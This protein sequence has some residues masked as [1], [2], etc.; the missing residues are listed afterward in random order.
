LFCSIKFIGQCGAQAKVNLKILVVDESAD[1]RSV[2]ES[3]LKGRGFNVVCAA[4]GKDALEKLRPDNFDLILAGVSIPSM[5]SIR[6]LQEC[7]CDEKLKR[8][9]FILITDVYIDHDDEDLASKIGAQAFIRRPLE[10]DDLVNTIEKVASG[11]PIALKRGRKP[12]P[13]SLNKAMVA[14]EERLLSR[15]E[16]RIK[17]LET[18]I[19]QHK[20]DKKAMQLGE[21]RYHLL[22]RTIPQGVVFQDAS[23]SIISANPAALNILG[24]SEDQI[25]GRTSYDPRWRAIREDGSDYPGDQHPAMIALRTGQTVKGAIMG[26]FNP[27]KEEYR[28]IKIDAIPLVENGDDRPYQ[29]YTTFSD[30]T[31]SFL[32][33]RA[34]QESESRLYAIIENTTD[35]IFS[36]DRDSHVIAANTMAKKYFQKAL[37]TELKEGMNMISTLDSERKSFWQDIIT[38]ALKGE[39]IIFEWHYDMDHQPLDLEFS[40]NPIIS[41]AGYITGLS[42]FGRDITERKIL[43]RITA[44]QHGLA[45]ALANTEEMDAAL[46][47][48]LEAALQ[49]SQMDS[50][51]VYLL[52]ESSGAFKAS[53]Y[54]G[55]SAETMAKFGYFPADSDNT[56]LIMRGKPSYARNDQFIPPFDEQFKDE[57]LTFV[58]TVP[59]LYRQK[60]TACLVL[61]S[62]EQNSIPEINLRALET[63][64]SDIGIAIERIKAR[65]ALRESEEKYRTLLDEMDEAY[66]EIDEKGNYTFFNDALCRMFGY[67]RQELMGM[68]YKVYTRPEDIKKHVSIF[69]SVYLTG[70]PV[71]RISL[72]FVRKDGKHVYVEESILPVRDNEGKIVGL[73]GLVHDITDR[74]EHEEKL[75]SR[76]LLLDSAYD[77]IIAF[78]E[79]GEISYVNE[80][81]AR[82][83][84]YTVDQLLSMNIRQLVHPADIPMLEEKLATA[85]READLS[86]E[87]ACVTGDNTTIEVEA[88]VRS[89]EI[90][91]RRVNI[92]VLRDITERKKMEEQLKD[93]LQQV[94]MTLEGTIEAIATMSEIRDPY[95]A[96][97]QHRVTRL[98][99][100]IAREMGL[101]EEK[102]LALRVAGLLHDVGKVYV[103]SEILSKPGKLA[104]LERNLVRAHAEAG[105]NIVKTIKFPW[106]VCRIVLQHHERMNGSGYP[107][108]L[109]GDQIVAEARILAV[110]DVVEAMLSHRPYRPALGL[111]K[112]LEEITT[113][114]GILYDEQAVDACV[115]LFTEKGFTFDG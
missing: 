38:R 72:V 63:I 69:S 15:L 8:I 93:A 46:K 54:K 40:V 16:G 11:K 44:I 49:I 67:S 53:S 84:H 78:D 80:T 62:H 22:F 35:A 106:P 115:R 90:E 64:A 109:K 48:C 6:L 110:A 39:R 68:N 61:C 17:E 29:V 89:I 94:N 71:K 3:W 83:Y 10:P 100:A 36:V 2:F 58:A 20:T 60:I 77:S 32:S 98:A 103:P 73:R 97:H 59:V 86:F 34:L 47:D 19:K 104:E 33:G 4:N 1:N 7:R 82:S 105:Y 18:E 66:Y 55:F 37:G 99:L 50:G 45:S 111:D 112:A 107:E 23:G 79:N 5:D 57:K 70:I 43:D 81:A 91:G 75:R 96:R 31:D 87:I 9:P 30:I 102:M 28:W 85:T 14:L 65:C 101:P 27:L 41:P 76:A 25:M 21:E 114:R 113:N 52:D 51:V 42:F 13:T 95:T 88:R 24:L 56:R 92:S 108:G 12:K 26:I 74:V